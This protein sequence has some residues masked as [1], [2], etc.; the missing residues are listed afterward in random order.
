MAA[1]KDLISTFTEICFH[2]SEDMKIKMQIVM[3]AYEPR[4]IKFNHSACKH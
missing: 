2:G 4:G 3:C 1:Y